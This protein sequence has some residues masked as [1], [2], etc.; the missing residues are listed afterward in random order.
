MMKRDVS[1]AKPYD[2]GYQ[3]PN[4]TFPRR[5]QMVRVAFSGV[6][7]CV[8][9]SFGMPKVALTS[10]PQHAP[11][12]THRCEAK[13]HDETECFRCKA[14]PPF[15]IQYGQNSVTCTNGVVH[16]RPP[17]PPRARPTPLHAHIDAGRSH[18]MKQNV[19]VARRYPPFAIW[20]VQNSVSCR[21]S[22]VNSRGEAT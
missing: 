10:H 9:H 13:P 6:L 7:P 22:V 14:L 19:S 11:A 8:C 3:Y 20:Y 21:N 15:S 12:C 5:F 4:G 18:M 17:P 2:E 1:E 16:A